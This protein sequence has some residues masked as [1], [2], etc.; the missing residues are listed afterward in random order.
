MDKELLMRIETELGKVGVR[1]RRLRKERGWRLGDLA[2]RTGLSTSY[3]SRIEGGERE[4]SIAA[5]FAVA[6]AYGVPFHSLFEPEPEAEE[7]VVTRGEGVEIQRGNGLLYGILSGGGRSFSLQPL[8]VIVPAEREG[9]EKYRHEGEEWLY[10][11]SGRLSLKLGDR[12]YELRP[13]DSAHFDA[14]EPHR[15]A[16]L[17]GEDAEVILVAAAVAHPLLRSYM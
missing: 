9:E 2:E 10:V 13:G 1:L 17:G 3:L 15:L 5:L 6:R 8:R 12:E 4:P 14:S 11:L 16:A 7:R